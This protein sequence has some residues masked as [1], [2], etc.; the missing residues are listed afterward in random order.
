MVKILIILFISRIPSAV[1]MTPSEDE[2]LLQEFGVS[3]STSL[4]ENI[5]NE[6][7]VNISFDSLLINDSN[8]SLSPSDSRPPVANQK[9][10]KKWE[11]RSFS[12]D[13][14]AIMEDI[15]RKTNYPDKYA[16]EDVAVRFNVPE[17][18]IAVWFRNRRAKQK[19]T[20]KLVKYHQSMK[21]SNV[22]GD[23]DR[24]RTHS[25]QEASVLF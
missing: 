11:R 3:S 8:E 7:T 13:E 6:P 18:K 15:F 2:K 17:V 9:L 24:L 20:E 16:R 25:T 4:S 19:Q 22:S 21:P 10:K 14:V 23:S 5:E 1:M 12:P